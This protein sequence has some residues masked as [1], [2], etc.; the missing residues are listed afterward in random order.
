MLVK[1]KRKE[2]PREGYALHCQDVYKK[3]GNRGALCN[4]DLSVRSGEFCTIVGPSGCGK[5]TLLR[6]IV[7]QEQPTEGEIT[8]K[9]EFIR[10]PDPNRGIVYQKYSLYPHLTALENVILGKK[11]TAG[12]WGRIKQKQAFQDEAMFYL[13]RVNLAEHY[14]KYPHQLS[15]GMQQR[16][17]IAQSLIMHPQ[18][19]LM[20]EPFGALDPGTREAM[21]ALLIDLWEEY[22]M[23]FFFV[24][25]DLEEAIYLGSRIIVLSQYYQDGEGK[26]TDC[27]HGAT[28]V[29]DYPIETGQATTIKNTKMFGNSWLQVLSKKNLSF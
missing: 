14:D 9:G 20:D 27:D 29:A 21:Q 26:G 24:T 25:H 2:L 15:G 1:G 13:K 8:L 6:L 22:K 12:F 10:E 3:Y 18:I 19:L 4:I 16:V 7:G 23:T 28:I 5:S 11:L 17:A